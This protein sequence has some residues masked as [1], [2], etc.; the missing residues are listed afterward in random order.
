V[1]GKEKKDR[2]TAEMRKQATEALSGWRKQD[3]DT[4]WR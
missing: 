3:E 1:K 4:V 2:A